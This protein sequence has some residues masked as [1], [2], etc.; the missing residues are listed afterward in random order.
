[1]II[2][3]VNIITAVSRHIIGTL[4][5]HLRHTLG[6]FWAQ[7]DVTQK[8]NTSLA[9]R[10]QVSRRAISLLGGT[11]WAA[12]E[13]PPPQTD[14]SSNASNRTTTSYTFDRRKQPTFPAMSDNANKSDSQPPSKSESA[15]RDEATDIFQKHVDQRLDSVRQDIKKHV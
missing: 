9:E 7:L 4:W 13:K 1:M 10:T 3:Q 8:I 6:S 2:C 5:A 15:E 14:K 11:V 12:Y